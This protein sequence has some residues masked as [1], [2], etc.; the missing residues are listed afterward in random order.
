MLPYYDSMVGK[1]IVHAETRELA[2]AKML[3]ALS[4]LEIEGLKTNRAFHLDILNH[5]DFLEQRVHTKWLE[6]DWK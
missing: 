6:T 2:I 3:Q 1:L 5:P 4:E